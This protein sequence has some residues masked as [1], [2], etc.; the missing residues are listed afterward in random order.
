MRR[1]GR[2]MLKKIPTRNLRLG[3]HLHRLEGSWMNHPFWRT[4]FVLEQAEDLKRLH[5]CGVAECWIDVAL[6][7]DVAEADGVAAPASPVAAAAEPLPQEAAASA[8]E[9]RPLP[10]ARPPLPAPG[11]R[12]ETAT[13]FGEELKEAAAICKRGHEAVLRMFGEAR[14]GRAVDTEGCRAL[15]EDVAASVARNA[16]ALV[17]LARLKTKDDYTYLHSVAVCALM[18]ALGRQLEMDEAKCREAGLAGLVHDVGKALMPLEVLGKPGKLTD[19]EWRV[20]RSHPERGH[21]LLLESGTAGAAALDVALHHH[22]RID[23]QGY[24]HKLAGDA[25][26]ELARMGAICDVYDAITSNR[27]YKA[28]WDPAESVAKMASWKGHFDA[29]MFAAFVHSLGIY[30]TG[31]VV[32]LESGRLAVVAEQNPGALL[33]PVVM[34]FYSTRAQMQVEP[35]RLD[36][37]R[38]GCNDRIVAREAGA[39]AQFRRLDELWMNPA[40]ARSLAG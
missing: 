9:A 26:S 33:T 36:L 18:V 21:R 2:Q 20:M 31:S 25:I 30:P 14:M 4:R 13:S 22:E 23:G 37:S 40:P 38:Q 6:G 39:A 27:P 3:M 17:S 10:Q 12:R 1:T 7:V 15:V 11:P 24:P 32:R 29:G 28:G 16:G 34:V 8:P 35:L 19:E 5:E